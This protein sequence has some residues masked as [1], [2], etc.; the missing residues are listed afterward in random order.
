MLE[1]RLPSCWQAGEPL[2]DQLLSPS[3]TVMPMVS[4]AV[5]LQKKTYA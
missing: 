3:Q 2:P 5:R 4:V 1:D